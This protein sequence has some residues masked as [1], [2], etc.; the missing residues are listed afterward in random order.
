MSQESKCPF[1]GQHGARTASQMQSNTHW[2]P[3]RLNLQI[4]RQHSERSNPDP[5]FDYAEAFIKL[6]LAAVK[7][8]LHALMTVSYTHL[9]LPT[10][11][12]V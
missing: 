2:W 12:S 9:T 11:Y 3:N 5:D 6:D 4:L 8:D 7:A 1:A 10:I